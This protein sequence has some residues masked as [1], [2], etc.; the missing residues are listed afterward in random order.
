LSKKT[1]AIAVYDYTAQ[2]DGDL[3]FKAGDRIEIVEKGEDENEWW[4]GRLNGAEGQF[5]ANYTRIE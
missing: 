4:V 1:Y 2:A 5:P 3:T